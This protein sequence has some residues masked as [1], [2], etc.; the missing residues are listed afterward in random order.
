VNKNS[1]FFI[2]ILSLVILSGCANRF[3]QPSLEDLSLIGI[4]G[5]DYMDGKQ[6]RVTVSFPPAEKEIKN[7]E[8]LTTEVSMIQESL[9]ELAKKSDKNLVTTQLRVILFGEEF[10]RKQGLENTIKALYRNASIGDSVYIAIVKGKVEDVIKNEY[11]DQP[12]TSTYFNN[13]LH[14]RRP[15]SFHPFTTIHDFIFSLTDE[16]SDPIVP[17]LEIKN[18]SDIE[19]TGVALFNSGKMV[20][21]IT[22][23]EAN[24]ANW[25][26]KDTPLANMKFVISDNEEERE[27]V[28][29]TFLLGHERIQS[30]GNL[31]EPVFTIKLKLK[32]N[33]L[34]YNGKK[35]LEND[36]VVNQMEKSISKE[37]E[38][39]TLD[40]LSKL[41]ALNVDS[42]RIGEYLRMH[43]TDNKWSKEKWKQ[44]FP[45]AK[46]NVVAK[47]EIKSSG[48]ME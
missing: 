6:T 43:V 37:I 16:V 9:M 23:E 47:V 11:K 39:R 38:N 25:I 46:F 4:M 20:D 35:N 34:E 8:K 42:I 18:G 10:A 26:F 36:D 13:L 17:Y 3:E 41:Q 15:T 2:V 44:S 5:F 12:R 22:P 7:E 32:A 33:I 40:L 31:K 27:E 14:P 1:R 48:T 29:M 19:I 45:T 24:I 30:N 28:I 21:S